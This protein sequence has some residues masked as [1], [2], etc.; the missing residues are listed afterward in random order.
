MF[1]DL[2]RRPAAARAVDPR[3]WTDPSAQEQM[4]DC[5]PDQNKPEGCVN[6]R[7]RW[8]CSAPLYFSTAQ[9]V[10]PVSP[11]ED[12]H[13]A[14]QS[15]EIC[16]LSR[17]MSIPVAGACLDGLPEGLL[18]IPHFFFF[19]AIHRRLLERCQKSKND[20]IAKFLIS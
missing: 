17:K 8:L 5:T 14:A 16:P 6:E 12:L 10:C 9:S 20:S 18:F 7:P 4:T 2:R 3:V 19:P 13:G 11:S 15:V 1:A